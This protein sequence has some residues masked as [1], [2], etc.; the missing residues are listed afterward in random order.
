MNGE[1]YLEENIV[2]QLFQLKT[3]KCRRITVPGLVR[4]SSA[5]YYYEGSQ[6]T[7]FTGFVQNGSESYELQTTAKS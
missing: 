1:I 2:V 7:D 4:E 6:E 5:K 3:I